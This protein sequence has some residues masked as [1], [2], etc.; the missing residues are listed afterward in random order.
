MQ[1]SAKPAKLFPVKDGYVLCPR[2]LEHK[3][4]NKLQEIPPDMS[5]TRLRL[6][7]RQCKSRYVVNI[8]EGQCREDQSR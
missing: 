7:C 5:A 3:I 6:F 2:C 8:A 4:R 1:S